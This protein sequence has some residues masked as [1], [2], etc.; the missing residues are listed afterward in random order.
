M[1]CARGPLHKSNMLVVARVDYG[2][3][4]RVGLLFDNNRN[5]EA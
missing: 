2:D 5:G 1:N 3:N 4:N